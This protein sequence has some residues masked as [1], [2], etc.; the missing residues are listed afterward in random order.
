[1]KRILLSVMTVALVAGAA[2]AASG[3][4]F[5]DTET[6][7]DNTFQAGELDLQIDSTAHYAGLTC[8]EVDPGV[9]EWVEDVPNTSTR[10]DLI[11]EPCDGSWDLTDLFEEKFFSFSD[12]KP[13][14][15]G[16]NTISLH[17]FDNDAWACMDISPLENDDNGLTEPEEEAGD[18]TGGDDEGEL[19]QN[20]EFF[21]WKDDGDNVFEPDGNDQTPNTADD[22]FPLFSNV[23]GPASDVLNGVTYPLADSNGNVFDPLGGGPLIGSND[24]FI[25]LA[26]CAGGIGISGG[27]I[28]CDGDVM[29]NDTQSDSLTADLS[30]RVEQ[31]RNNPDFVCEPL[32]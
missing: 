3:A 22:E 20:L 13:G 27:D 8:T 15:A 11:G 9:F 30:F 21:S 26:W 5:S 28:S 24:Y 10:P 2:F 16:E 17:V 6:S 12:V 7:F 14:D 31:S 18:T 25:G 4:F 1:M 32:D 29:G 19:A 23:S